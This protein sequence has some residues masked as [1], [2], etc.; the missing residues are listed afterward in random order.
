MLSEVVVNCLSVCQS[1][2]C[3][4]ICLSVYLSI[5]DVVVKMLS[6]VVVNW[7]TSAEQPGGAHVTSHLC[8]ARYSIIIGK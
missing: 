8:H 7:N 1:S 5:L 3:L 4:S 6:E 2:V